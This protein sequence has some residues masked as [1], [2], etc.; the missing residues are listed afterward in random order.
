[1]GEVK[2]GLELCHAMSVKPHSAAIVAGEEHSVHGSA[3]ASSMLQP[4]H[5]AKTSIG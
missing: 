1:M 4:N 5:G 3:D 2:P